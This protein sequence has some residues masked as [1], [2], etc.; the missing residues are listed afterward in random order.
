VKRKLTLAKA[1]AQ[2]LETER[3]I[4]GLKPLRDEAAAV[5]LE[6]AERTGRRVY[7]AGKIAVEQTGGSLVLDQP[8]VREYLGPQRLSEFMK[9]TK[10]GLTLKLLR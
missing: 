10:L 1:V 3:A 2:W 7:G 4:Q 6:N 5:I 9:R 8:A